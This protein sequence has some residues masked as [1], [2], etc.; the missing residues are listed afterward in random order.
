MVGGKY[1]ALRVCTSGGL[2]V[3]W[4]IDQFLLLLLSKNV[5]KVLLYFQ[6][7]LILPHY[8]R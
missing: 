4:A 2:L 1:C 5:K 6:D 8:Q 3:Y 7:N